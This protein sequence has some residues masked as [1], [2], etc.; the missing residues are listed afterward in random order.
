M[1][2]TDHA[3]RAYYQQFTGRKW[4]D[5]ANYNLMLDSGA[6]G[7]EACVKLICDAA[8]AVKG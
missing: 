3:R 6:L 1:K 5:C 2:K 4:G 7:F 8:T